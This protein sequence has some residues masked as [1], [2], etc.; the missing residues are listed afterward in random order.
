MTAQ[1]ALAGTPAFPAPAGRSLAALRRLLGPVAEAAMQAAAAF[2]A[3]RPLQDASG[4]VTGDPVLAARRLDGAVAAVRAAAG[5]LGQEAFAAALAADVAAWRAAGLATPPLFDRTRDAYRPPAG[6]AP[7][8][9]AG[10]V[11][12]TNG[13]V[14]RGHFLELFLAWRE[15]PAECKAVAADRPHPKNTCQSTRLIIASRGFA[16]GNCIV[17]FPENVAAR[18]ALAGQD[19]ALF[20]FNKFHRIYREQTLPEVRRRFGPSDLLTGAAD[21]V[22]GTLDEATCYRARCVWGYLHD[23][24]HHRGPRPFDEQMHVKL[25]WF[26]GLLEEIKVDAETA[27]ACLDGAVPHGEAILQFVLFERMLRYPRQPD[28]TRNFDSATGVL[29][30]EWLRD[31]E[32][33]R[34]AGGGRLTLDRG[35]LAEGLR[36]LVDPRAG[37]GNTSPTTPATRPRPGPWSAACCRKARRESATPYRRVSRRRSG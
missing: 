35:R 21:W 6:D 2:D 18:G 23:C 17:F 13:P 33:I 8:L 24:F 4:A 26:A 25:T 29:L 12:A 31:R 34:P 19:Y 11:L 7:T 22:S 37:A 32:A 16:E 30:Y 36:A 27:L 14:P 15:E 9:F 20:F 1:V 28:A 5:L 10:P 3:L